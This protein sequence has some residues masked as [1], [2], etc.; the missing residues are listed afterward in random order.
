M[1]LCLSDGDWLFHTY[2][3]MVAIMTLGV[4]PVETTVTIF[5]GKWHSGYNPMKHKV[6]SAPC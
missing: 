2:R 5:R 4:N 1:A 3:D 6:G